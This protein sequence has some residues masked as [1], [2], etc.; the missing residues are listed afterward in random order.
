M[1]IKRNIQ[2]ID[3]VEIDFQLPYFFKMG[4]GTYGAV[5]EERNS[6]LVGETEIRTLRYGCDIY[7]SDPEH[8]EITA[9]EFT[10]KF[11]RVLEGIQ[12]FK[13]QF[14]KQ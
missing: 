6:V 7:L 2:I 12:S 5:L 8:I 13:S 11:D 1:K 10:R 9:E 14:F 4:S 3:E